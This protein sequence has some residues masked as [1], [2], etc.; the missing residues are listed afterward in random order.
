MKIKDI[1]KLDN[2]KEYVVVSKAQLS[3][4]D[5]YY[6]A[7]IDN[8]ND[9]MVCFKKDNDVIEVDDGDLMVNLLPLFLNNAE[10]TE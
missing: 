3:N 10:I 8:P 5:Y 6:L 4:E 2:Q 7:N 1:V 9:F